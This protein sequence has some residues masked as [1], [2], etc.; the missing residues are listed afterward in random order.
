[1]A[2]AASRE[3]LR[4]VLQTG[5]VAELATLNEWDNLSNE[6]LL[7]ALGPEVGKLSKTQAFEQDTNG[8]G[9]RVGKLKVAVKVDSPPRAS[10][11]DSTWG[12]EPPG[13]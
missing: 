8:E 12:P 5:S 6:D 1:M 11:R 9:A 2:A 10:G 7:M 3:R 4:S 13:R